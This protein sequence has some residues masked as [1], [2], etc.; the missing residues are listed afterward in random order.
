MFE[1]FKVALKKKDNR[2]VYSGYILEILENNFYKI[3]INSDSE[4]TVIAFGLAKGFKINDFVLVE[5]K[6]NLAYALPFGEQN[7]NPDLNLLHQ[8]D[9]L[10]KSNLKSN[11]KIIKSIQLFLHDL[12]ICRNCNNTDGMLSQ[13]IV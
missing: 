12:F 13:R 6:Q 11:E 10:K 5:I 1:N 4:K 2:K 8:I 3:S 9:F 7:A